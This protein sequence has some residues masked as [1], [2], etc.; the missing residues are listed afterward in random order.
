MNESQTEETAAEAYPARIAHSLVSGESA[1]ST[2]V[3]RATI[4]LI[5]AAAAWAATSSAVLPPGILDVENKFFLAGWLPFFLRAK[6]G[7]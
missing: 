3:A 6:G 5:C 1:R 2:P 7:S 4:P